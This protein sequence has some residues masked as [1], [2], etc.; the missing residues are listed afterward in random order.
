MKN[1]AS[2]LAL[3]GIIIL[4]GVAFWAAAYLIALVG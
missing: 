3:A 4:T 2:N 1:L